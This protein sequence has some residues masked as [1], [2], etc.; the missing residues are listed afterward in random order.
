MKELEGKIDSLEGDMAN[1]G[2]EDLW[3]TIEKC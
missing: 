3:K 2:E 1:Y